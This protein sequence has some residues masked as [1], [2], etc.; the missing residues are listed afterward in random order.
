VITEASDKL[1]DH[2]LMNRGLVFSMRTHSFSEM[3][4]TRCCPR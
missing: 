3:I 4:E 1:A 2:I